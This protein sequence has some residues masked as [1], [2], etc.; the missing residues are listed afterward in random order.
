MKITI[1]ILFTQKVLAAQQFLLGTAF[2]RPNNL[3]REPAIQGAL[4]NVTSLLNAV[5][6]S[7]KTQ[8]RQEIGNETAVSLRVVS[9]HDETPLLDFH[10]T[11]TG[12]NLSAGSVAEVDADS[13]YRIGSISKLF[14]VYGLLLN[15]G[16]QIWD[17]PVTE[18]IPELE[19]VAAAAGNASAL[20]AVR[21]REVTVGA[22]ASQV[23]G[24]ARDC[25]Y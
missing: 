20:E 1:V 18:I 25:T 2:E 9:L 11:P 16:S 19:A 21:W 13:M 12:L 5:L 7:G 17:R 14:T 10:H 15:G 6:A 22:L 24:L 3:A 23:A 4:N 8:F